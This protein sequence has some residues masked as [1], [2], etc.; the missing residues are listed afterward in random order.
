MEEVLLNKVKTVGDVAHGSIVAPPADTFVSDSTCL[1]GTFTTSIS[2]SG[3]RSFR[4]EPRSVRRHGPKSETS[5]RSAIKRIQTFPGDLSSLSCGASTPSLSGSVSSWRQRSQPSDGS[6]SYLRHVTSKELVQA[7]NVISVSLGTCF[8]SSDGYAIS[9]EELEPIGADGKRC[10]GRQALSRLSRR[11]LSSMRSG[12]SSSMLSG[13][14]LPK[15]SVVGA[16]QYGSVWRARS[17][18]T[19]MVYAVKTT[20]VATKD[21]SLALRELEVCELV[22]NAPHPCLV[23]VFSVLHETESGIC[24]MVMEY[25]PGGDLQ[26]RIRQARG[27][28]FGRELSYMPPVQSDRW[29]AEIFLGLEHIHLVVGLLFRDVKPANIVL[30]SGDRAKL[31]DFGVS[32]HGAASEGAWSF[33]FPAGTL[34]YIAPEISE[35][36]KH[37]YRADLYSFGV[38]LWVLLTGGVTDND[39]PMP[40]MNGVDDEWKLMADCLEKPGDCSAQ[41]L[42]EPALALV[43]GLVERSPTLRPDHSDI[44]GHEMFASQMLPDALSDVQSSEVCAPCAPTDDRWETVVDWL[45]RDNET[46]QAHLCGNP[47]CIRGYSWP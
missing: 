22:R 12:S 25:C 16:G 27:E 35:N 37:D 8:H 1:G 45:Q 28:T 32:R 44:R 17:T 24:Y 13:F 33:G 3:S 46:P 6:G 30:S 5:L 26:G 41:A 4:S 42:E 36:E 40:P 2:T 14:Q 9:A 29:A 10:G 7:A 20:R 47:S 18:R 34:G 31:T 23:R 11:K 21:D 43:R 15:E 38:L 39:E 19:N